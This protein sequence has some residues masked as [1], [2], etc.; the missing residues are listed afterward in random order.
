MSTIYTVTQI[1]NHCKN[2]LEKQFTQI[3]IK[4]E[5]SKPKKYSSGHCKLQS[6]PSCV[7]YDM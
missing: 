3:W 7:Y 6:A 5:V 2:V 1:N 4:G